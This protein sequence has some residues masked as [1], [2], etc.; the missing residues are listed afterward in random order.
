MAKRMILVDEKMLEFQPMLRHFQSKQDQQPAEQSVKSTISKDMVDTLEDTAIPE[1][2]KAKQYRI[3]LNRYLHTKRKL[4]E[5]PPLID[6]KPTV[7]QLLDIKDVK[8]KIRKSTRIKK[9]RFNWE[10]WK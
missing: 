6:F 10:S 9:K 1:D 3:Q 2:V 4:A 7:D 5:E 8:P